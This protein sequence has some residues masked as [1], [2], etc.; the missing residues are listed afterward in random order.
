MY[1]EHESHLTRLLMFPPKPQISWIRH[2]DVHVLSV[3]SDTFTSDRRFRSVFLEDEGRLS[4]SI[5]GVEAADEGGYECQV[6]RCSPFNTC[7]D[8]KGAVQ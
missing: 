5:R 3:G 2:R 4:L 7:G 1:L 8:T 6:R